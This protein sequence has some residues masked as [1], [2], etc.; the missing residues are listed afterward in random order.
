MDATRNTEDELD[1][2]SRLSPNEIDPKAKGEQA[3]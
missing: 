2:A 3:R 1:R